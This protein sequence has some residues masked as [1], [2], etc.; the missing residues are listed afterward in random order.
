[1][2]KTNNVRFDGFYAKRTLHYL[3]YSFDRF[4]LSISS[5]GK[6][7][8]NCR[9]STSSGVGN[10]FSFSDLYNTIMPND[11]HLQLEL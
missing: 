11:M 1:M 2:N 4:F 6:M 8:S 7:N 9:V 5:L 10:C 3:C